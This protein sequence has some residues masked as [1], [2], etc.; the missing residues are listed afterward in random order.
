MIPGSSRPSTPL[1][2]PSRHAAAFTL[3]ELLTVIAIIGILSSIIIA[4]VRSARETARQSRCQASLR[5]LGQAV[6]LY[7]TENANFLPPNYAYSGGTTSNIWT[8]V[9]RPWFSITDLNSNGP[10]TDQMAAHLTCASA[11]DTDRP[12]LWWESNYAAGLCFGRDGIRRR[13][14]VQTPSR[15]VMFMENT[16]KGAR[17]VLPTPLPWTT[18]PTR[19]GATFNVVFLDG[20]A[21]RVRAAEVPQTFDAPFWAEK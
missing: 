2:R 12:A 4:S 7:K 19:H 16:N 18:L 15:T 6:L 21:E 5:A 11:P 1:P 13:D 20:H 9:L 8:V 14:T 3:I 17:A 10:G